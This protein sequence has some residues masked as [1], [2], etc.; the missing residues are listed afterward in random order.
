MQR[1]SKLPHILFLS[2][3]TLLV[4]GCA[5]TNPGTGAKISYHLP[6]TDAVAEIVLN[7]KAC[8][9]DKD[10]PSL[11]GTL[12]LTPKVTADAPLYTVDGALLGSGHIKRAVGI[13]TNDD[14]ILV[15]IN[16]DNSDRSPQIVGNVLQIAVKVG[17]LAAGV[18]PAAPFVG[19]KRPYPLCNAT[20][21]AARARADTI[22]ARILA[23]RQELAALPAGQPIGDADRQ[24]ARDIYHLSLERT[25]LDPLLTI[26]AKIKLKIDR[27][28]LAP[29]V[30]DGGKPTGAYG[31]PGKPDPSDFEQFFWDGTTTDDSNKAVRQA[32]LD[33]LLAF[34]WSVEP[35]P[36]PPGATM[37]LLA[38]P[39]SLDPCKLAMWVPHPE[40]L[41]VKGS[42]TV[43]DSTF[44][45]AQWNDPASLCLSVGFGESRSVALSFDKFGRT[46]EFTWSSDARAE[47][48]TGALSGYADTLAPLRPKLFPTEGERMQSE[49]DRLELKQKLDKLRACELAKQNGG[50]CAE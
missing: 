22:E 2:T 25:A 40:I 11:T 1:L 43:G 20:T 28:A 42:Q 27:T 49:A 13:K 41:H 14:A 48:I 9:T 12:D 34:K 32:E 39:K 7:L 5:T 45:A 37:A 33:R 19:E 29:V 17:M 31:V 6:R 50:T 21:K 47:N 35:A 8:E 24:K 26:T 15:G 38:A 18:A 16:A 23:L 10:P 36:V 46:Q 4:A 30:G 3:A 44:P